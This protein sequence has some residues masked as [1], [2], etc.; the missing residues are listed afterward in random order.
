MCHM[1]VYV[2]NVSVRGGFDKELFSVALIQPTLHPPRQQRK[3]ENTIER[4]L[5]YLSVSLENC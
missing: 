1:V 2:K 3:G 4:N 5:L